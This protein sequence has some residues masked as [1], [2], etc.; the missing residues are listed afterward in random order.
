MVVVVV[1]DLW[2]RLD[3]WIDVLVDVDVASLQCLSQP[4]LV[5]GLT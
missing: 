1:V 3:G 5:V 2:D 4:T